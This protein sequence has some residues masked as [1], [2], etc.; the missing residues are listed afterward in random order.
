MQTVQILNI[1]SRETM[2]DYVPNTRDYLT[3]KYRKM[4]FGH[5]LNKVC[6]YCTLK[7]FL[8]SGTDKSV[9]NL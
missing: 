6:L 2:N 9:I 7:I 4:A 5:V 8:A 3:L 1:A